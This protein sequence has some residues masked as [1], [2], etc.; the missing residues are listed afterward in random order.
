MSLPTLEEFIEQT[1]T[2]EQARE[3]I[4]GVLRDSRASGV[5]DEGIAAMLAYWMMGHIELA[6]KE[7]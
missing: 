7:R 6:R 5:P 1:L 4:Q 2:K 3:H